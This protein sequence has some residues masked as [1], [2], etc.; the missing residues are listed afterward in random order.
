[1]T[2]F[3]SDKKPVYDFKIRVFCIFIVVRVCVKKVESTSSPSKEE[4][5]LIP[6]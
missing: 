5:G 2:L 6:S 1:M 3:C 4:Y